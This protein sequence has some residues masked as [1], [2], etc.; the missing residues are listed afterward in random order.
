MN[1]GSGGITYNA[2]LGKQVN[3]WSNC[4]IKRSETKKQWFNRISPVRLQG[5]YEDLSLFHEKLL[6]KA[7][8]MG[9]LCNCIIDSSINSYPINRTTKLIN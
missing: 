7:N 2:T 3:T 1:R 4:T 8:K 6:T 5:I 9:K